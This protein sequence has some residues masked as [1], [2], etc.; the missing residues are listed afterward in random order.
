MQQV[1]TYSIVHYLTRQQVYTIQY[2]YTPC[3]YCTYI[4]HILQH[5]TDILT[6]VHIVP[7]HPT[8]IQYLHCTMYVLTLHQHTV[9]CT[10]R[11]TRTYVKEHKKY[12]VGFPVLCATVV[13]LPAQLQYCR[14][15]T[16][17]GRG[18]AIVLHYTDWNH[19]GD[20]RGVIDM[21]KRI[22][23]HKWRLHT[24]ILSISVENAQLF[25]HQR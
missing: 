6:L 20:F 16:T 15:K 2:T 5:A 12:S 17:F 8:G 10:S 18:V 25:S 24:I 22:A 21:R 7:H 4:L 11:Y 9:H 14:E 3:I 23:W 19:C 13:I 1:Y